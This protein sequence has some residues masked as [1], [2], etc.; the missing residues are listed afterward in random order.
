MPK[1]WWLAGLHFFVLKEPAGKLS[2]CS[3]ATEPL[4]YGVLPLEF[5]LIVDLQGHCKIQIK[6][7]T[8]C[9]SI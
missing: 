3:A 2:V 7:N 9:C 8:K 4:P 6:I 5:E 1:V